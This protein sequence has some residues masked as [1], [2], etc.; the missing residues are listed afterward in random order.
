MPSLYEGLKPEV[1]D[2]LSAAVGRILQRK[3]DL[4]LSGFWSL[5][6]LGAHAGDYHW[7]TKWASKLSFTEFRTKHAPWQME[8]VSNQAYPAQAVLGLLLFHLEA[9]HARRESTESAPW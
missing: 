3:S 6:E 4:N 1:P 2:V 7:L 5:A 8:N 9:E